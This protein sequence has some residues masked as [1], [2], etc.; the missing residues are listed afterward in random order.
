MLTA[1]I[2]A[3]EGSVRCP[4]KCGRELGPGDGTLL[5]RKCR[6]AVNS[7]QFDRVCVY[8]ASERYAADVSS[9]EVELITQPKELATTGARFADVVAFGVGAARAEDVAWL[10]PTAPF[11]GAESMVALAKA[12]W[13]RSGDSL[14]AVK[15]LK[16]FIMT[17]RGPVNYQT[18]RDHAYSQDLYGYYRWSGGAFVAPGVFMLQWRYLHGPRPSLYRVSD[19]EAIDIDTELDWLTATSAYRHLEEE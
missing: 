12:Y 16:Q 6:Q 15:A 14:V 2:P 7:R 8:T 10:P 5:Q 3:R 17:D 18:G 1:I 13:S 19:V 11:F 9:Y 4:D